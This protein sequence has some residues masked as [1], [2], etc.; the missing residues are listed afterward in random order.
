MPGSVC[1]I[2]R[3]SRRTLQSI[4][5]GQLRIHTPNRTYVFPDSASPAKVQAEIRVVRPAFWLR[6]CLMSDL[7]FS[8]AY[9]FGDIECD[10]LIA[11]F[12]VSNSIDN[13]F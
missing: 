1:S 11:V 6:L 9:M 3:Q 5:Y 2:D 13:P 10:D 7:G 12:T 4:Q 8:E